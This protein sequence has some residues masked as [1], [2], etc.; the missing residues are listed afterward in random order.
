M[1]KHHLDQFSWNIK[2]F[3]F[4]AQ[5]KDKANFYQIHNPQDNAAV[6][7]QILER[8]D[9]A[10]FFCLFLNATYNSEKNQLNSDKILER[11][12]L[13]LF[14]QILG[15]EDTISLWTATINY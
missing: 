7:I 5:L 8:S 11:H 14:Q 3:F 12:M 13:K 1:A 15:Y 6:T 4:K 10:G 2:Q 9:L